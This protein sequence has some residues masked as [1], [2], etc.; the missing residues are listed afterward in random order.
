MLAIWALRDRYIVHA[1]GSTLSLTGACILMLPG[2]SI[3]SRAGAPRALGWAAVGLPAAALVLVLLM[4]WSDGE[5]TFSR[6]AGTGAIAAFTAAQFALLYVMRANEVL[7]PLYLTALA[8]ASFLALGLFILIWQPDRIEGEM[9]VRILGAVGVVDACSTLVLIVM[10]RLRRTPHEAAV[11]GQVREIHLRCPRCAQEQDLPVGSA[12]C[13]A[14]GLKIAIA[15]E[16]TNCAN[17][18]YALKDLPS[19]VCPECGTPF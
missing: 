14:C 12:S 5:E 16:A 18:G 9:A 17:C 1:F 8:A 11:I 10:V 15:I 6:V 2:G 19:R 7:R 4:I 3:L 13:C